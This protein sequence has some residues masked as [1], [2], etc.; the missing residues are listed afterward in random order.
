MLNCFL[1]M[2]EVNSKEDNKLTP[3]MLEDALQ[4]LQQFKDKVMNQKVSKE[5]EEKDEESVDPLNH[6][7][8]YHEGQFLTIDNDEIHDETSEQDSIKPKDTSAKANEDDQSSEVP[9]SSMV[10]D[11]EIVMDYFSHSILKKEQE[12]LES[13]KKEAKDKLLQDPYLKKL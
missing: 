2:A 9:N 10:K 12:E 4:D 1:N 5:E 11:L 3:K 7:S 6:D 13:L 8:L